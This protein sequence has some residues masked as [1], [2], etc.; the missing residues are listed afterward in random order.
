MERLP[1]FAR[2]SGCVTSKGSMVKGKGV[3]SEMTDERSPESL[4]GV[5][6]RAR[7][8]IKSGQGSLNSDA[9]ANLLTLSGRPSQT[10]APVNSATSRANK[11]K[12]IWDQTFKT[13]DLDG[14]AQ[15]SAIW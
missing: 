3:Q 8:G 11:A 5:D 12:D 10:T 15:A 14:L 4:P 1:Y 6:T 2:A 7:E 9:R 13:S